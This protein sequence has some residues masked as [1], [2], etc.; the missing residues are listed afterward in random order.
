MLGIQGT[1]PPFYSQFP[2]GRAV[3]ASA[4]I[5]VHC[6]SVLVHGCTIDQ[7]LLRSYGGMSGWFFTHHGSF[8][9]D[10]KLC[11]V[12]SCSPRYPPSI[13]EGVLDMLEI[14]QLCINQ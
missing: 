8:Q 10:C 5:S 14:N 2:M 4:S 12:C 6:L 1:A 7:I 13:L 3:S 11:G 9:E